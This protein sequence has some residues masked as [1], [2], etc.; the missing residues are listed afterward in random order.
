MGIQGRCGGGGIIHDEGKGEGAAPTVTDGATG[1][2]R[3]WV[4]EAQDDSHQLYHHVFFHRCP[5]RRGHLFVFWFVFFVFS[6]RLKVL[7]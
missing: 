4:D 5:G 6:R 1:G 7:C 3:Q 2:Q